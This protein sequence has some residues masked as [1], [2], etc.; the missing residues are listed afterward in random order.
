MWMPCETIHW[1]GSDRVYGVCKLSLKDNHNSRHNTQPAKL[2]SQHLLKTAHNYYYRINF[3]LHAR[4]LW[5]SLW[6]GLWAQA[7][8]TFPAIYLNN[9][10]VPWGL[11]LVYY[12]WTVC[13]C[14]QDI[15]LKW[16][17]F[18]SK[19]VLSSLPIHGEPTIYSL[20]LP[21]HIHSCGL[22]IMH[23][24]I[25]TVCVYRNWNGWNLIRLLSVSFESNNKYVV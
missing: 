22:L 5:K 4:K 11:L 15:P 10:H 20:P 9:L 3:T 1:I 6:I 17:R 13:C 21:R 14:T 19:S 16:I 23:I 8:Q 25:D 24:D 18:M 7:S 12:N 2:L